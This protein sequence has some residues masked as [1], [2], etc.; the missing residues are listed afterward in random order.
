MLHNDF[1]IRVEQNN[2]HYLSRIHVEVV[3]AKVLSNLT[4]YD[5]Q[6]LPEVVE[7]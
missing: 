4:S 5:E 6:F 2:M 3:T 1:G 7:T